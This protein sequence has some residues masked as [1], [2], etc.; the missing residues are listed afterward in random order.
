MVS[1]EQLNPGHEYHVSFSFDTVYSLTSKPLYYSNPGFQVFN[2][3]TNEYVYNE[4]PTY[5]LTGQPNFSGSNLIFNEENNHWAMNN[6]IR[7]DVF[8]GI[9]LDILQTYITPQLIQQKQAG[10]EIV[11]V[12]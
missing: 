4:S 12:M 7:S 3:T 9:Q 8:E 1:R 10:L 6:Q 5:D 2:K 11:S